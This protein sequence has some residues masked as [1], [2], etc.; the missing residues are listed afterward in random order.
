MSTKRLAAKAKAAIAAVFALTILA[1]AA[2]QPAAAGVKV[3]VLECVVAPG[4]GL[5]I[6][7]SKAL[8]CTLSPAAGPPERYSG[9]I[10]KIGVDI[11]FTGRS[12]IVWAVFAAQPGYLPGS[13]AGTYVGISAEASV[14]IG[15]G[16][17]ALLGGS[18][19]S[20]ALQ[21]LSV[22]AQLGLNLAAGVTGLNLVRR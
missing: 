13:L 1:T 15:V 17:N 10:N 20:V 19:K 7:S 14:A 5:I 21:P 4:I 16:A 22:Q 12:V 8:A 18:N 6:V 9:R 2:P 3:G 11:G